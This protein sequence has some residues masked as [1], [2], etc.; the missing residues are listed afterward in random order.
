M[1]LQVLLSKDRPL[2]R[3][4]KTLVTPEEP[5]DERGTENEKEY[6]SRI[7]HVFSRDRQVGRERQPDYD[8]DKET[9]GVDIDSISPSSERERT[10]G[11][12][13]SSDLEDEERAHDLEVR[14]A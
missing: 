10:P 6:G 1:Y 11:W 3:H 13:P 4:G 2:S 7:V 5:I 8:E 12:L 14:G 9:D